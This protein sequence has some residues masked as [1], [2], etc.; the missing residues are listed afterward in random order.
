VLR[1]SERCLSIKIVRAGSNSLPVKL[2]GAQ[3][4]QG[5]HP[6]SHFRFLQYAAQRSGDLLIR[7]GIDKDR[8]ISG[9]LGQ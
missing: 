6:D 7:E 1:A 8:R 9:N 3:F 4:A 5:A 2:G